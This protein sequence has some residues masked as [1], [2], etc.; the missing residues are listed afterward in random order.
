[1]GNVKSGVLDEGLVW[2]EETDHITEHRVVRLRGTTDHAI[3]NALLNCSRDIAPVH[4]R[5]FEP[6]CLGSQSADLCAPY[7]DVEILVIGRTGIFR[8]LGGSDSDKSFREDTK[9]FQSQP[10]QTFCIDAVE[11]R[12]RRVNLF[13]FLVGAH[14]VRQRIDFQHRV[15]MAVD[16]C[17]A[18]INDPL[19]HIVKH[20]FPVSELS[21]RE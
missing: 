20:D 21:S 9:Q 13:H 17:V 16:E 4:R 18:D 2:R 3:H 10:V 5:C 14:Q 6:D 11:V 19:G 1:M 15:V 7:P 8:R 12:T